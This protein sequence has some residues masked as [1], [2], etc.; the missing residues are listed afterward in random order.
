MAVGGST[1]S[2][3]STAVFSASIAGTSWQTDSV[4]AFLVYESRE[5]VKIMTITGYSS[6]RLVTISLQD[7]TTASDSSLAVQSYPVDSWGDASA[8]VYA[9]NPIRIGRDSVWQQEGTGISGQAAVSASDGADRKVT[10]S[11]SFTARVVV[12]DSATGRLSTDTVAVTDG[13]FKNISYSYL[14]HP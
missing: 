7:T 11:F 14:M 10:G 13:V 9:Y 8:F 2:A 4:S 3:D 1:L 12:I 5:R 6:N